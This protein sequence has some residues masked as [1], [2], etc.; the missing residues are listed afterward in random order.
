M[1]WF[2]HVAERFKPLVACLTFSIA[3][4]VRKCD[5]LSF[6]LSEDTFSDV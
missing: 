2:A 3:E 4:T 1:S 6:Y 5:G